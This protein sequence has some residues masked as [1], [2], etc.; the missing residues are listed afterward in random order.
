MNL[1]PEGDST[2]LLDSQWGVIPFRVDVTT[3]TSATSFKVFPSGAPFT[4][5]VI[6]FEGI[7]QG[8]GAGGMT[9]V[10]NSNAGTAITDSISLAALPDQAK[11][12]CATIND[13][14]WTVNKGDVLSVVTATSPLT[15]ASVILV[16]VEV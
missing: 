6:G 7:M 14:Q 5:R 16:R 8:A 11:W 4:C 12:D 1:A 10:L 2:N 13:A 15:R 9:I 3:D